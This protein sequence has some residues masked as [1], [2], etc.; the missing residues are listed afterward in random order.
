MND[1]RSGTAKTPALPAWPPLQG[2]YT[3]HRARMPCARCSTCRSERT[4][5]ATGKIAALETLP[6]CAAADSTSI[7]VIPRKR[8]SSSSLG[9]LVGMMPNYK[10][11]SVAWPLRESNAITLRGLGTPYGISTARPSHFYNMP[12]CSFPAQALSSTG[13]ALCE[14]RRIRPCVLSAGISKHKACPISLKGLHREF[15]PRHSRSE[16]TGR[17]PSGAKKNCGFYG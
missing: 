2:I 3:Q 11:F 9:E 5:R 1:L 16:L 4:P 14:P 8:S 17:G 15:D 12:T 10:S 7:D 6:S 13:L